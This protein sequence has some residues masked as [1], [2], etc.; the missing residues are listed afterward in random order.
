[1]AEAAALLH[2]RR[3]IMKGLRKDMAG[4]KGLTQTRATILVNSVEFN[5]VP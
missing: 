1:M 4:I 2:T 5:Q 3:G